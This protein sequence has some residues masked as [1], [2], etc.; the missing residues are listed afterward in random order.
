MWKRALKMRKEYADV[1][2]HGQ[3]EVYDWDNLNT[4]TY[5]KD[6]YGKRVLVVLAF[7]DEEEDFV[8][9]PALRHCK[10]HLLI[11]NVDKLQDK[12]SPWEARAYLVE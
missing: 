3:F 5:V 4:F 7:S 10:L 9:P 12:L 2:I 6:Y 8:V 1:L 11:S